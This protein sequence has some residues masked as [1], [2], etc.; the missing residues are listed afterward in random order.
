MY[1]CSRC[2]DY[3]HNKRTCNVINPGI[4]CEN[5]ENSSYGTTYLGS[6]ISLFSSDI[7]STLTQFDADEFKTV[8]EHHSFEVQK[9]SVEELE[10]LTDNNLKKDDT[11]E[12]FEL[13]A[14]NKL[15]KDDSDP[16]SVS[17]QLKIEH[18]FEEESC[19]QLKVYSELIYEDD[20][21]EDQGL[22]NLLY[23]Y[24]FLYYF[25]LI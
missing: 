9:G 13:T 8:L 17:S 20:F 1:Y 7:F 3:G 2:N 12:A 5:Y 22:F 16:L 21:N 11:D 15:K 14:E 6:N 23:H 19:T 10:F 18:T 4:T 25:I 24:I